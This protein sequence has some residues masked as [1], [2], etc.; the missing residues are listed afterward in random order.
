MGPAQSV[1][2][3]TS[4]NIAPATSAESLASA[5]KGRGESEASSDGG[6]SDPVSDAAREPATPAEVSNGAARPTFSSPTFSGGGIDDSFYSASPDDRPGQSTRLDDVPLA[7][8]PAE[9]SCSVCIDVEK[10]ALSRARLAQAL[11]A[12]LAAERTFSGRMML[13]AAGRRGS[14]LS[15]KLP[16]SNPDLPSAAGEAL[17]LDRGK[18]QP[19]SYA[20]ATAAEWRMRSTDVRGAAMPGADS[21]RGRSARRGRRARKRGGS[22]RSDGDMICTWGDPGTGDT[23]TSS[24]GSLG[25]PAAGDLGDFHSGENESG[26]NSE[27]ILAPTSMLVEPT[28]TP[29]AHQGQVDDPLPLTIVTGVDISS[30]SGRSSRRSSLGSDITADEAEESPSHEDDFLDGEHFEGGFVEDDEVVIPHP[31]EMEVG[32]S[33]EPIKLRPKTALNEEMI[34]GWVSENGSGSIGSTADDP[35]LSASDDEAET[36]GRVYF[37]DWTNRV[38]SS[39]NLVAIAEEAQLSDTGSSDGVDDVSG[40]EEGGEVGLDSFELGRIVRDIETMALHGLSDNASASPPTLNGESEADG[41]NFKARQAPET[42]LSQKPLTYGSKGASLS[43]N[44]ADEEVLKING[45]TEENLSEVTLPLA[46]NPLSI[47]DRGKKAKTNGENSEVEKDTD[48]DHRPTDLAP[49]QECGESQSS[50][51][52]ITSKMYDSDLS[53]TSKSAVV[54]RRYSLGSA[55]RRSSLDSSGRR[56]RRGSLGSDSIRSSLDMSERRQ[57]L[58]LVDLRGI[59]EEKEENQGRFDKANKSGAAPPSSSISFQRRSSAPQMRSSHGQCSSSRLG[60]MD[61]TISALSLSF[62]PEGGPRGILS[63]SSSRR[64][65][66]GGS[67]TTSVSNNSSVGSSGKRAGRRG[68][69][70]VNVDV[71]EYKKKVVPKTDKVKQVIRSAIASNLLF[72][73]CSGEE[74]SDLIDV[75]QPR[76]VIS[77]TVI[78]KEGDKGDEFYVMEKGTVNVFVGDTNVCALSAGSG[79]GE[80]AL[81]YGCPRSATLRAKHDCKLWSIDRHSFR[82]ITGQYKRKRMKI[83]IEFLKRVKLKDKV[84]G[85]VLSA[86]TI[87]AMASATR[88]D[89]F[90]K[91]EIIIKKGESGDIFYMIEKGFVDVFIDEE[92]EEPVATLCSGQFFGETALLSDVVRSAT[93]VAKTDVVCLVLMRDDFAQTLGN[94]EELIR[95][96]NGRASQS[97]NNEAD[98]VVEPIPF[99]EDPSAG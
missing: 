80:V 28:P 93:C 12:E 18:R 22:E 61:T 49:I 83:K 17:L 87:T 85:D 89:I 9:R 72:A 54:Q 14:D 75:F 25:W 27:R 46:D 11:E 5:V 58:G 98:L 86:E 67:T 48:D 57:S 66:I 92:A 37:T 51:S 44:F 38:S 24:A 52:I 32:D 88:S 62:A 70:H 60:S 10:E 6:T 76:N 47:P 8:G 42:A 40:D 65:S 97:K 68:R 78:I 26:S 36:G 30:S 79:F 35:D 90:Q 69:V 73:T 2:M 34:C 82:A 21:S 81:L 19:V 63:E 91:G 1:E 99:S 95:D 94:L 16:S 50:V 74:L 29:V 71:M 15:G 45:P 4:H 20:E 77:G 84:L 53:Q 31:I 33:S 96:A 23:D 41:I 56:E 64:W 13:N 55:S 59:S 3:T 43:S 39:D 7:L